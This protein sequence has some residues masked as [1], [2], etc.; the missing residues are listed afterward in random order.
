[1]HIHE[2]MLNKKAEMKIILIRLIKK[3][4][5]IHLYTIKQK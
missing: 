3:F 5:L 1:M 4:S 2:K